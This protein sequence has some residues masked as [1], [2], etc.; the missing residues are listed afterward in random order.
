MTDQVTIWQPDG[1][2]R[3]FRGGVLFAEAGPRDAMALVSGLPP[4]DPPPDPLK[5]LREFAAREPAVAAML[6]KI[7]RAGALTDVAKDEADAL[8]GKSAAG[9]RA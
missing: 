2:V 3:V 8:E 9:L 1:G 5:P 6:V 7:A 4:V